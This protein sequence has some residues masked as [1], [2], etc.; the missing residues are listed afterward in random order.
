MQQCSRNKLLVD[1]VADEKKK[2][3]ENG[4]FEKDYNVA[5]CVHPLRPQMTAKGKVPAGSSVAFAV[6]E[7]CKSA[8]VRKSFM[9]RGIAQIGKRDL[10][11]G[12]TVWRNVPRVQWKLR[13]LQ[14]GELLR[15]RLLPEGGGGGGG[16]KNP[17]RT[18]L[19]IVVAVIAI[20]VTWG[21]ATAPVFAAGGA[22]AGMGG[23]AGG[24]AGLAVSTIGM[25]LVNAIAPIKPANASTKGLSAVSSSESQVYSISSGKNSINQWGRVPVPLGRGRF[26]PPKAASPYTQTIGEDIYLHELLCPGIGNLD[27]SDIKIGTTPIE[28][29]V[30]CQYELFR[31]DPANPKASNLYPTGVYQQDLS[32]Q[33]KSGVWN[34]RT[35]AECDSIELDFSFQG[36]CYYNDDSSKSTASVD[37]VVQYKKHESI[38]WNEVAT[39]QF[40]PARNYT[41][42]ASSVPSSSRTCVI[43]AN[44][45]DGVRLTWDTS[46]APA[47][48]AQLGVVTATKTIIS[49]TEYA[50]GNQWG[51]SYA[52]AVERSATVFNLSLVSGPV[53][54]STY[55]FSGFAISLT[56]GSSGSEATIS[57]S[58]GYLTAKNSVA[59]GSY[60]ITYSGAQSRL[61][62]KTYTITPP[63]RGVYDVRVRRATDDS[64]DDRLVNESYWGALR[65]VSNDKPVDTDYPVN[66]LAVKIKATSQLSGA[67][68]TLTVYYEAKVKDWDVDTQTWITR[69]SSNPASL[70]RHILQDSDSFRMPQADSLLD[71]D[72]IQEAHEYW[73]TKGWNY[74]FVCD[75]DVSVFERLQSICAAGLASP[76]MVDGKWGIILDKPRTSVACAFTSANSWGWS[77][78]RTQVRLPNAI[79]CTFI[80]QDTWDSDMRVI[81]TDEVEG[82]TY[83]YES[84]EYEG[85]NDPSQ[86]YQ[87]A[88]FHY[89]DAKNRRRTIS[90]RCLDE[91][92]LC[93]RGDLV[94]CAAP[95]ISPHGLQVGRIR[96]IERDEDENVVALYTDQTQTT[97]LSGRRFGVKV[98]AQSGAVLHA[99]VL[100]ENV[101]SKKLT[102]IVPQAM[103]VNVGD[104]YAFGDYSEETF[105]AV[106]LGLKPNSDWTFDITLQDYVPTLY[107]DLSGPI[108]TWESIITTPISSKWKINSTPIFQ[109]VV[110][111]E[112][113]LLQTASGTIPRILISYS[114]PVNLDPRAVGVSFDISLAGQD[115][116]TS[117]AK[118][119]NLQES[120]V[121][122]SGVSEGEFYDIRARYVGTSGEIGDYVY[123]ENVEIIGKTTRPPDVTGF[124]AEIKDAGGITLSWDA[125][126]VADLSH[127]TID[128]AANLSTASTQIVAQVYNRIGEVEF[129][130]CAV[131]TI[132]LTSINAATASVNV[133]APASPV[134]TAK[135]SVGGAV[136]CWNDCAKTWPIATYTIVATDDADET[137]VLNSLELAMTPRTVGTYQFKAYAE[138]KFQNQSVT[139]TNNITVTSPANPSPSISIDGADIVV[140]WPMV[141]S[142]FPVDFYEVYTVDWTLGK[143]S[144][145]NSIRFPATGIGVREFRV[146]A[147]DVAGN[148]SEWVETSL[149][150]TAPLTPSVQ[151]ILNDNKDG[152]VLS[153]QNS[154]SSLPIVAWDVVRQWDN[155]LG[156]GIIET[157]EEDFGRL[158]VDS[159]LVQSV[160]VGEHHYMVRGVDSAG[161]RSLWGEV[162][163]TA[164]PPGKVTF[165]SSSAIDNNFLLYWT[166]PDSIFFAI[167]YYVFGEVD[168]D[169]YEME[170]GRVDAR[171]SSSFESASG[172][173]TYRVTPVDTAGNRG[174]SADIS[175]TISQP[176]DFMLFHDYDSLFNGTKTNFALDGRGSM[177][178]PVLENETWQANAERIAALLS[179]TA[180]NLTWQQ[181]VTGGYEYYSSPYS[182]TGTYVETVNVGTVIPSTK[183]TVTVSRTVLEGNPN[184]TCKIETSRDK[185]TWVVDA[186]NAFETFATDFQYVRYTFTV[187]GGLLQI[188]NIN[189][190]LSLKR[191]TDFGT[192]SVTASDNG[193]GYPGDP[194]QAG[195]WV[196]FNLAFTDINGAPVCTIVNNNSANP[197]T[198]YTVFVDTL[199]PTGF[200]VFVLDKNGNR[201]AANVSWM[202]QGV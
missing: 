6:E 117:V 192:V 47:G 151:I 92:L 172:E 22:F 48:D 186:A 1:L 111:D 114:H 200:R 146:R 123:S 133:I 61:L 18:I 97:D 169:G 144:K 160:I 189:Y 100:P 82:D 64:N 171:F 26:A 20:V 78:K 191:K 134:L 36:L 195:K 174:E 154:G 28:E 79:H 71:L 106:V 105:P 161:N 56:N 132:K 74:N 175:M 31:Y 81:A 88:R 181:K 99:E 157:L 11:K 152:C 179:T 50:T 37:F 141:S 187:A 17:L 197:L 184:L 43:S 176:P 41:I 9:R 27:I 91:A 168:S 194:M 68:D 30:D 193:A 119:V 85:V 156:G 53:V 52:G 166:E 199:N 126:N 182:G 170:I 33:L 102:L 23:L 108:P 143:K 103:D 35:T 15:F 65:S 69:Y 164:M 24:L 130:C 150:I 162:V 80:N 38:T 153:W 49:W 116:W 107:D 32:V 86:V 46:T 87:L 115:K 8:G 165:S 139:S 90:L 142:F 39:R 135:A 95:N 196:P 122:L 73:K 89:A 21:V 140:S 159:L 66:L 183:I 51:I 67:L 98:Y 190:N 40:L 201:A 124:V 155:D 110:T 137:Y 7:A 167:A 63:E 55:D 59:L 19:T 29:Y 93:T 94:D 44:T 58:G 13:K 42:P 101:T 131:D 57:V 177:Y 148:A 75:A 83:K 113:A 62:R 149:T 188:R 14:E 104:K 2:R 25:V 120:E 76:T 10:E 163:F 158:D 136:I 127:Y 198:P 12:Q 72:S 128:G 138:D 16:S 84:Q 4:V 34:S 180:A 125:V 145:S 112:S 109:S 173:Y 60:N 77:F 178:A 121:Y 45:T 185:S 202:V 70:F 147:V 5:G 129:T 96:G 54:S 3:Q 118:N